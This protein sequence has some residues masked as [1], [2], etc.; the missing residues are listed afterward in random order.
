VDAIREN[1]DGDDMTSIPTWRPIKSSGEPV[2]GYW[3]VYA[4]TRE[5]AV[6]M[7]EERM[8]RRAYFVL[9]REWK[10]DGERVEE[11]GE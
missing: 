6:K 2:S 4:K 7:L 10:A 9:L 3:R 5:A 1:Y 11:V 8:Q